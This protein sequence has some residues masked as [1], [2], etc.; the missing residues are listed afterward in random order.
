MYIA[1]TRFNNKTYVENI[2]WKIKND[3]N[4]AIYGC[5]HRICEKI[6]PYK[7]IIVIE[8]N[9]DLNLITGI[10]CVTNYLRFNK[11]Y[12]IHEENKYNRYVYKGKKRISRENI[13]PY[14]LEQLEYIL[15]TTSQH[16]KRLRGITCIPV[17]R[18]GEKID[19]DFS[20]GDKVKKIKGTHIGT[21][22][23]I[24]DKKGEKI[25]VKYE[26]NNILK[27][28]SSRYAL[29]NYVKLRKKEKQVKKQGQ[30]KCR[31][32]GSYK[33]NH[34]C[35]SIVYNKKLKDTIYNYLLDLFKH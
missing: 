9:N 26:E 13:E 28:W 32:C 34:N 31:L 17:R 25:K 18:L 29:T 3:Y 4:G 33:K 1:T 15:F 12:K 7:K 19:T 22:G 16:Y 14:V 11:T 5:P 23:I 24:I 20:I 30:Y 6:A 21:H 27:I 2:K 8:M 35:I 10:G